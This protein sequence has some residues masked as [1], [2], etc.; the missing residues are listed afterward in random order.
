MFH[1]L[2]GV[3]LVLGGCLAVYASYSEGAVVAFRNAALITGW[4]CVGSILASL[5]TLAARR[6]AGEKVGRPGFGEL[7]AA[8]T[9]FFTG[10]M[11]LYVSYFEWS[12]LPSAPLSHAV[13][14]PAF[15]PHTDYKLAANV[16]LFPSASV[17]PAS[18]KTIEPMA[19]MGVISELPKSLAPRPAKQL[20]AG[21]SLQHIT[22]DPCSSLTGVAS[23]QCNRCLTESGLWRMMCDERARIEYCGDRQDLSCPSPIPASPPQ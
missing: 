13:A 9:T 5:C 14:A 6:R 3:T 12:E 17:F 19:P 15:D 21:L 10:A 7:T 2:L 1:L 4:L 11:M 8:A 18:L 22:D 23:L 20:V 16:A